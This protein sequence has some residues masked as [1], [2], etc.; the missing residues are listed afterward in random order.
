MAR[1]AGV[2]RSIVSY[3]IN[4][5]PR[6]VSE[7]KRQRVL[8]AIERLDYRPNKHAQMLIQEKWESVAAN[9][10][11]VVIS[12]VNAFKRPYYGEILAGL[13]E[14]AHRRGYHIRF[15]R[16]F[17]ALRNP[18]LL[19]QLIHKHEVSG[20]VLLALDQ[21]LHTAADRELLEKIVGR[22]K[23]VVCLE[24]HHKGLLSVTFDRYRA[25]FDAAAHLLGLG[26]R[27][28]A[29][30][31]PADERVG[32]VRAALSE[33]G[34]ALTREANDAHSGFEQAVALKET[35]SLTALVAGSDEVAF[36]V[37]KA[38]HR[39]GVRVP[40]DLAVV[41][42]D[43][44]DLAEFAL[45]AL[46]TVNVPKRELGQQAVRTLLEQGEGLPVTVTLPTNL[47]VRESCGARKTY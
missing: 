1:L 26:H 43:N 20:L 21:V 33:A 42:I 16:L 8:R 22:V 11:G 38:C 7:E 32:G 24:W 12:S 35:A 40:D 9:Q 41:S 19:N 28:L 23:R 25:A 45:P 5:G 29:Y 47:V 14:E 34:L 27:T 13:H 17:E 18:A 2:S 44:I 36:G 4:N 46:T 30:I 6:S 10:L 39:Q 3:V 37:L 15:I 31:G